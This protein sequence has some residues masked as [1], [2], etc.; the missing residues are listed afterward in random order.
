MKKTKII[1]NLL[2]CFFIPLVV[3]ILFILCSGNNTSETSTIVSKGQLLQTG[4][5]NIPVSQEITPFPS[6]AS[7]T[8]L[9]KDDVDKFIA[10]YYQAGRKGT[11]IF[12]KNKLQDDL[13]ISEEFQIENERYLAQREKLI[14]CVVGI[15]NKYGFAGAV[16]GLTGI[17]LIIWFGI[18]TVCE[19]I[20][21]LILRFLAYVVSRLV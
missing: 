20:K 21:Y 1:L 10:A 8:K 14:N 9:N 3:V 4:Q 15:F 5:R 6:T 12:K 17:S 13:V 2:S 7:S 16:I 11:N 18:A 19:F